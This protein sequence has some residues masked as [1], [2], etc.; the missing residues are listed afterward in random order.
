MSRPN[1][2]WICS[3]QQRYDTL[4]CYGNA[5]VHTP[6]LDQ[7]AKRGALFLNAFSQSPV[8]TPSRAAFLT[9]RYPR[10]CRTRQNGADIP[11]DEV[12]V[13]RI[14][15]DAGYR[16][17]LAGKLH[18]SACNPSVCAT[19]ER[20]IDDGYADF[21]WSHHSGPGWGA[22][23]EYWGWLADKGM[24]YETPT[25]PE[26]SCVRLGMPAEAHQTTWC[27]EKA[28]DFVRARA[29]DGQ[30]WLFSVNLF[31]PHHAFD[32]P[33]ACLARYVERLDEIPMPNYLPGEL[34]GKPAY[35]AYDHDGAYGRRAGF[36]YDQM[37]ERDHRFVRAAYWAMCDLIDE[38]VGRM[39]TALE[40]TGQA[41]NT[42]VVFT[43]DHGEMLGDHGIY[44][45]GPFF[46]EPAIRVPLIVAWPDHIAAQ[47]SSALVEL[48]D[49]PQTLL[50]A[51]GLPHD[52]GMQGQSLW[53]LLR[54]AAPGH[55][56]R[57]DVYCEYYNAMPWHQAPT[58]QMTMVRTERLKL[59]VDHS[60]SEGELYDLQR[61][62]CE[63]RN[64]WDEPD[65]AAA[66]TEMLVRLC[67][68]MA[69]TVDPLPLRRAA[70]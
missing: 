62:P 59:T 31:D 2:L 28:C 10:T 34:E 27:A 32:P 14:L 38:Q 25:H 19:M 12:L 26:C 17:G 41:A 58:A 60:A 67:N 8:C 5:Y 43:S 23:N 57:E 64:L 44:L 68:R 22:H 21:H 16:C 46:Y 42:I 7:L 55:Q 30:P 1:I 61:D 45:K 40:E 36:S 52:P 29:E 15:A 65:Y 37:S 11:E 24:A 47:V 9:G 18:L 56:H 48:V 6:H 33:E 54:G 13:T 69:W 49:L 39:L 3:D 51:V 63:T 4:G 20:R 66:K 70:W 53:P 50:D 35:Q